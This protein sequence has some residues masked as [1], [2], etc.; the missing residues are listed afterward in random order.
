MR[1]WVGLARASETHPLL[2][3]DSASNTI[4]A[5]SPHEFALSAKKAV[6]TI[7]NLHL[8]TSLFMIAYI[9]SPGPFLYF[10]QLNKLS[11]QALLFSKKVII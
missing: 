2:P 8:F 10:L 9:N 7:F 3:F 11:P 1:F 4:R 6:A 5:V